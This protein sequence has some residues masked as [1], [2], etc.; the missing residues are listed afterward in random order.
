MR[1]FISFRNRS[2]ITCLFQNRRL[3]QVRL[4]ALLL[5]SACTPLVPEHQLK[6]PEGMTDLSISRQLEQY[7]SDIA[8]KVECIN[9]VV[10]SYRGQSFVS[11][12]PLKI[13]ESDNSFSMA[14]LNPMGVLL[15]QVQVKNGEIEKAYTLPEF[16]ELKKAVQTIRTDIQRL[17]FDRS[18][19][20]AGRK[21]YRKPE[22]VSFKM[23]G[24]E[25]G[26]IQYIFSGEPLRLIS[27][28]FFRDGEKVWSADYYSY[29][30][31][32]K[33]KIF[34]Q[35]TFFKHYMH[36]YTLAITTKKYMNREN[37]PVE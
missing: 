18:V 32:E 24:E 35:E 19:T 7:N 27:K 4:L 13:D 9:S 8:T 14:A 29:L 25:D 20:T 3:L 22:S 1:D 2:A 12:G 5:I 17:Y 16:K 11:L 26:V 10:F 6:L 21:I 36:H 15:F 34:P 30:T 23:E 33:G 31:D 28:I 37:E